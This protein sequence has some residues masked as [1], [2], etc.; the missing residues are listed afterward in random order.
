[1]GSE[2]QVVGD[3]VVAGVESVVVADKGKIVR[4]VPGGAREGRGAVGRVRGNGW[5][6]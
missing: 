5:S 4:L 2:K 6:N 1:M 3:T